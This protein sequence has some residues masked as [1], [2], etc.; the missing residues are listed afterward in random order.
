MHLQGVK[1][2]SLLS[3]RHVMY[4]SSYVVV[5]IDFHV[6]QWR[7]FNHLTFFNLM[8]NPFVYIVSFGDA[9]V[10]K[11]FMIV[12]LFSFCS[13]FCSLLVVSRCFHQC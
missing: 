5:E 8:I 11:T 6:E 10:Y 1:D 2:V 4:I 12:C 9:L 13:F 3:V 7:C